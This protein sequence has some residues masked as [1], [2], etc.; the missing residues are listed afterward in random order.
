MHFAVGGCIVIVGSCFFFFL[1]TGTKE[2]RLTAGVGAVAGKVCDHALV[3]GLLGG[4]GAGCRGGTLAPVVLGTGGFL[5]GVT[6]VYM[7]GEQIAPCELVSTMLALVRPIACV[8]GGVS[9]QQRERRKRTDEISCGGRRAG[10][11]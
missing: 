11:G 1:A 4:G 6:L 7:P 3:T 2:K 5:C 9:S 10:D 8:C